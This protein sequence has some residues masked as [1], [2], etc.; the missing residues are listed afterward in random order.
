METQSARN[1]AVP[2]VLKVADA[3]KLLLVSER[4]LRAMVAAREVPCS[5]VG[6]SLR[7]LR[8]RLLAYVEANEI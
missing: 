6:G 2:E 1:E 7:F 4:K 3:A 8:K 5:R